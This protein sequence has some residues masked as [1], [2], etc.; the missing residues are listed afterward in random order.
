MSQRLAGTC[1]LC[2]RT[3]PPVSSFLGVCGDCLRARPEEALPYGRRAHARAR[4]E[5][6]LPE[7]PPDRAEGVRC[8][9]CLHDCRMVEGELGYCGLRENRGG[10][11]L[12]RAGTPRRGM[13]HWYYDPLPTNC[14]ADWVCPGRYVPGKVNLAV[15]YGACTF[16]CLGCQNWQ[17]RDLVPDV[18]EFSAE[19]L[20]AAADA[21]T[22]CIC[23]FGGDPSPQMPHALATGRIVAGRGVRV[24]WE[25]N[26]TMEPKLLDRAADL[27]LA[28]GGLVKFDLKAWSEPLHMALTGFTNRRTLDN[29]ARVAR[30]IQE[31]TEIP[32]LVAS[33]LLVPGYVDA[34]EVE[35]LARFIASFS[36]DI[37][38]ALLAF[39][40]AFCFSDLPTT[41]REHAEECLAA[42]QGAGL[43]N[44][45]VGNRHLLGSA[46]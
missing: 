15:F 1:R 39:G 38:Y 22:E 31:R 23:Y 36:P 33:T 45:R 3:R 28:S 44:V 6:G 26:G 13:L 8:G 4:R 12:H 14:V 34:V 25:T 43:R 16:D 41:S 19:E 5:F 9:L 42:A 21:R 27:S 40:P 46:Y 32:L 37:P 24:C 20:A 2:G 17:Y 18:D 29:F 11:L 35:A 30:R 10:R 7:R